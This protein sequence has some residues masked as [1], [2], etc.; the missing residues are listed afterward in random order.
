MLRELIIETLSNKQVLI[1]KT[2][3]ILDVLEDQ[4]F[5]LEG[6]GWLDDDSEEGLESQI[7]SIVES[8]LDHNEQAIGILMTLEEGLDLISN[9]WLDDD[10]ETL[11]AIVIRQH[12]KPW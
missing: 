6:N 8:T 1:D 10:P 7:K 12:S 5:S 9:G 4:G 11:K 2:H 3:A